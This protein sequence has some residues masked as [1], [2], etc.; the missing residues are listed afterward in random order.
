MKLLRT[1]PPVA[2]E[3]PFSHLIRLTAANRESTPVRL[4][5]QCQAYPRNH[6][7]PGFIDASALAK[8]NGTLVNEFS[9]SFEAFRRQERGTS[10]ISGVPVLVGGIRSLNDASFC[11]QCARDDGIKKSVWHLSNYSSCHKHRVAQGLACA[12]CGRPASWNRPG[13]LR[14]GCGGELVAKE[15]RRATG[16]ESAMCGLMHRA[17]FP[18]DP[19]LDVKSMPIDALGRLPLPDLQRVIRFFASHTIEVRRSSQG[20]VESRVLANTSVGAA[21]FEEWPF[22]FRTALDAIERVRGKPIHV[23]DVRR[24]WIC[25]MLGE[26]RLKRPEFEFIR[27]EIEQRVPPNRRERRN[28]I[29][30]V[31]YFEIES[32]AKKLGVD[33]RT[34]LKGCRDGTVRCTQTTRNGV[35]GLVVDHENLPAHLLSAG[36]PIGIRDAARTIGIPL[37]LLKLAEASRLFT[38]TLRSFHFRGVGWTR[39]DVHR[40]SLRLDEGGARNCLSPPARK[41]T[42]VPLRS[43]LRES[44]LSLDYRHSLLKRYLS[45]KLVVVQRGKGFDGVL[46]EGRLRSTE[47]ERIWTKGRRSV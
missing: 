41:G 33:P 1:V 24:N 25:H 36:T 20:K 8:A 46:V 15:T 42:F 9:R 30:D 19:V 38:K 18:G 43:V 23:G 27:N 45:G 17:F 12:H 3:S 28:V 11:L 26:K 16:A 35:D 5:R 37:R 44:F 6:L 7:I 10:T 32:S 31:V 14:C 40:I 22:G 4:L 29:A 47:A 13:L 21:A 2:G 34:L 39:E